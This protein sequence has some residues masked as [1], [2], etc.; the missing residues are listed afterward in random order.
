MATNSVRRLRWTPCTD[1]NTDL[2]VVKEQHLD[3]ESRHFLHSVVFLVG[4]L[5]VVRAFLSAFPVALF[6][7][8]VV[9]VFALT[10]VLRLARLAHARRSR[11]P[12]RVVARNCIFCRFRRV[13]SMCTL[14]NFDLKFKQFKLLNVNRFFFPKSLLYREVQL[15][16]TPE[17]K[18]QYVV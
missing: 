17:I 12:A 18:V 5:L 14:D 2:L 9:V 10:D 6:L 7:I 8:V 4:L 13:E 11:P 1:L 15:D 16:F 3:V